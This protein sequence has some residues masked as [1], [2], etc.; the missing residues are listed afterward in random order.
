MTTQSG[1]SGLAAG[2]LPWATSASVMTPIVF[3][4]SLVPWAS[5]SSPPDISCP[6]RKPR[7]TGPGRWRPRMRYAMRIPTPATTKASTGA[8]RAGTRTLPTRPS[9]S[10]SPGPCAASVA[11]TTPPMSA[12]DEL[13][14]SPPYHVTRF[15]M[16]APTS[17]AKITVSVTPPVSTMPLAIVAA[18][19]SERNAP[20]K[21]STAAS[22]TA[23]RGGSARVEID[24]ATTLAVSWKPLVKSKASAVPT[25]R[26]SSRSESMPSPSGVLDD[27]ALEDVGGLLGRVDRVLEPLVDVLPADDRHRVDPVVEERRHRLARDA[28]AVVLEAVDLDGVVGDV[29]EVAQAGH[30]LGDLT[31]RVDEDLGQ[32]LGLVHRRLDLVEPEVV[33]ALLGE[34]H[35]VVERGGQLEDV[36][37]V[38]RGHEGLV[39]ALDDVVRDPVALLLADDDVAHERGRV[40]PALEHLLE[41]LGAPDHVGRRGFEQ[42]EVLGVTADEGVGQSTHRAAA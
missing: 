40:G 28:V 33:G 31:R 29:A 20:T 25:T 27:G 24:V 32:P 16:I 1:T 39:E 2:R 8:T 4:A 19:S 35:D 17:P 26:T 22:P 41:Q 15:Q 14:G 30:R 21:L 34:V 42:V 5:A 36:L 18:T 37:A 23:T 7:V 38:D 12:C 10:T 13:D 9:Q 3:C 11:P 6:R